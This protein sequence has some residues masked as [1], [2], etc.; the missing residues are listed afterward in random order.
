MVDFWTR[1]E[2]FKIKW[3]DIYLEHECPF[4]NSEDQKWHT[5][6][7]WKNW[8]IL[9]NIFPYSWNE[10]HLMAVPYKHKKYFLE[11][12]ED[13]I[14]EIKSIHQFI[15]D[16]YWDSEYFSSTRETMAN[17]SMEHFHMHFLPWKLQGKFLRNMLMKQGFPIKEDLD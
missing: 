4:C 17:R 14:L 9:H 15:K 6:W 16:F 5:V 11:L 10:Q 8:Y 12:D 3:N 1:E 13:E 2:Y 7:E